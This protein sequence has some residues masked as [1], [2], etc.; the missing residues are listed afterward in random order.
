MIEGQAIITNGIR[1]DF[2]HI[3]AMPFNWRDRSPHAPGL[4]PYGDDET[5][6]IVPVAQDGSGLTMALP[7]RAIR[8]HHSAPYEHL[9]A[10]LHG[11]SGEIDPRAS[12]DLWRRILA[13]NR[14]LAA[15]YPDLVPRRPEGYAD[16]PI[17]NAEPHEEDDDPPPI[18]DPPD[19]DP[20]PLDHL[21]GFGRR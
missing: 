11:D 20:P 7:E 16:E 8:I 17:K 13:R 10:S 1:S 18:I 2:I 9:P 6:E 5:H 15:A 3:I 21:G 14:W 19:D 4:D 12:T